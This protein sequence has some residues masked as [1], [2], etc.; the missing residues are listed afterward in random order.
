MTTES[1]SATIQNLA[2]TIRTEVSKSVMGHEETLK[3]LT[4]A[5]IIGGHVLLEGPPGIAKTLLAKSFA[6]VIGLKFKRIQFTPD[7]MPSDVTGVNIFDQR[8]GQFRFS[9]GP[10]FA[11]IV[12]ADEINRTPPKTQS[13]LLEAMEEHT[14][15]IDG[16]QNPLSEL[17]FVIATQNPIE[18]EGTFPLP[19]AQLDRFLFKLHMSY[20]KAE[21]ECAM[22]SK[23]STELLARSEE[24]SAEGSL[25]SLI[26]EAKRA[27][28]SITLSPS[29]ADYIVR[30]AEATRVH[31][32]VAL[33]VSPRGALNLALASKLNAALSGRDYAIP[34]DVKE[35]AFS[36][37]N[38]RI[39]F[40]PEA[41]D[42]A[43]DVKA[44]V[45]EIFTRVHAPSNIQ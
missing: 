45:Q 42:A 9:P 17:F 5:L 33:G 8:T 29:L 28:R 4:G 26:G 22:I 10:L 23:F 36:V 7:L 25:Q 44:V 21:M 43:R 41:Y 18:H 40:R 30:V 2:Q 6:K 13:A 15:T 1:P 38:H 31:P 24:R 27:L 34:D 11:D 3:L 32:D 16:V 35:M 20:P 19:E 39:L 14:I 12:L 37:M